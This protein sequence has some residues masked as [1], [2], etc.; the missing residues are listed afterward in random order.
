MAWT[1]SSER[2]PRGSQHPEDMPMKLSLIALAGS[3][4][5]LALACGNTDAPTVTPDQP[6]PVVEPPSAAAP[7]KMIDGTLLA[8][9]PV[10]LIVDPCFA[11]IG[12][13]AG[14]GSFLGLYDGGPATYEPPVPVDHRYPPAFAA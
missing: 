2:P 1:P 9:S 12:Q 10:N 13:Q 3:L 8:T 4:G 6:P 11:L 7:R 5:V 14:Y